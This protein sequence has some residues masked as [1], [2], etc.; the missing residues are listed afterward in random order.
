MTVLYLMWRAVSFD[1]NHPSMNMF[2]V[3]SDPYIPKRM[4]NYLL[5]IYAL[6]SLWIVLMPIHFYNTNKRKKELTST[7]N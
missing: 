4:L 3:Y 7:V 2:K 5:L 1:I 6:I